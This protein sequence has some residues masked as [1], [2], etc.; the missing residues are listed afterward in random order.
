M[1][2]RHLDFRLSSW[3]EWLT[4]TWAACRTRL[5]HSSSLQTAEIWR[6]WRWTLSLM[7]HGNV[8]IN[9]AVGGG[10]LSWTYLGGVGI[11]VHIVVAV[12]VE[13]Y[14]SFQFKQPCYTRQFRLTEL[15]Q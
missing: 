14:G 9:A 12:D 4:H 1:S 7:P 15:T 5:T 11:L 3:T 13:S 10:M 8:S 6:R 2:H